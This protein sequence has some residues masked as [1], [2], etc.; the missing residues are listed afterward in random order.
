VTG[1]PPAPGDGEP[2]FGLRRD[3][4]TFAPETLAQ[5]L[6]EFEL[7]REVGKGS[8]G[9][10]FEARVRATGQRVALK[11]LPPSLTLTER[12]LARFLR[13]GRIMARV[14]HPDIVGFLDQGTRGRLH[15]F[16]MEF[17]DGVTLQERL[18]VGPLPVRQACAIAARVGRALHFAHDRGVVHRDVKPGNVMLREPPRDGADADPQA[19]DAARVAITDF[20]LARET[21]TGSMTESGAIVGTP[22]YMAPELVLGGSAHAS[23]LGDVYSLGATL[24][25]LVTGQPPFDGPTAQSVLKAVLEQD[26]L[27]PRRLRR[28]LPPPVEAIVGKAMER[29]PGRRYGSALE[30]AEDLERFLRGERVQAR[31]P[32][33]LTRAL[34]YG[35]RRPLPTALL[36]LV[37]LLTIG[38]FVLVHERN[39]SVLH[40]SLADAERQLALASTTHDEQDRPRSSDARRDLTL[41]A[42]VAASEVIRRDG[43][44]ALAW[45]VRAKAHH[46]L[47]Q[48]AEAIYDLDAAERLL[49][50]ATPEVLHFRIDAL[51][52]QGDPVSMR[53]LPQDLTAL[54]GLDPGPHTRALVAEHLLDL[55]ELARGQEHDETLA[56][57]RDVLAGLGDEDPRAAVARARILELEGAA[58]EALAA[59][60]AASARHEGNLYVHLQAAA[61]FDRSGLIDESAREQELARLLQPEGVEARRATPVDLDG[62]GHFLTDVDRLLQAIEPAGERQRQPAEQ[63]R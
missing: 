8:M 42:V 25:A 32:G 37:V 50:S 4:Y 19:T 35:A 28:D 40:Q 20:G 54:L 9:I 27:P 55:A 63:R 51:R 44:F 52:Q 1:T 36:L 14:R 58:A 15:W 34:R 39:R 13:E 48:Y 5:D 33:R 24:Y 11:I 18:R 38:A 47:R 12:A 45:F 6:P 2:D 61:M 30:L 26:P 53:R 23:T 43:S 46:R 60:R 3:F 29:D 10:V 62:L 56:R 22:M 7:V 49:G 41:A 57:A 21:G 16:A 31:L 59:I 17:V